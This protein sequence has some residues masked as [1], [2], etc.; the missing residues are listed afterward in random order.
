MVV[1]S[2]LAGLFAANQLAREGEDVVLIERASEIGGM[3]RSIPG[4]NG[5]AFDIGTHFA[6]GTNNAEIDGVL[7]NDLGSLELWSFSESLK[8][9][10]YFNGVLNTETGCI[11]VRSLSEGDLVAAQE[12]F[13]T[14]PDVPANYR[15]A[16]DRSMKCFGP[17]VTEKIYSPV[18]ERLTGQKLESLAPE[19]IDQF[20]LSRLALFDAARAIELKRDLSFDAR[21]AFTRRTDG[22][23]SLTKYYPKKGGIGAWLDALGEKTI[24]LGAHFML[25]AGITGLEIEDGRVI[26]V[27]MGAERLACDRLVWTGPAEMLLFLAG[28][29][30]VGKPPLFCDLYTLNIISD[31]PLTTDLHWVC[32]YDEGFSSYRITQYPNITKGPV[33]PPPHHLTVEVLLQ[34]DE[35]PPAVDRIYDELRRIGLVEPKSVLRVVSS[36]RHPKALPVPAPDHRENAEVNRHAASALASNIVLAGRASVHFHQVPVL[37]HVHAVLKSGDGAEV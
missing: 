14:R 32:N 35:E 29:R 8:E 21:L 10:H 4:D 11:D 34:L 37:E 20:S 7:F 26:S 5:L 12:E 16:F 36:N 2:G 22:S 28:A 23:S 3:L 18:L 25:D 33:A 30:P 1:G 19:V 15:T 27:H 24:S 31:K 9:G 13:F 17:T 6:I